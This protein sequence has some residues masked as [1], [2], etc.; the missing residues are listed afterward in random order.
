MIHKSPFPDADLP[1]VPLT[2]YVFDNAQ[3]RANKAAFIDGPTG[4]VVT[5]GALLDSVQRLAGGLT[6][7]G[8]GS[9]QVLAI[10]APN[11]P[12]YAV[13][14][15][16]VAMTGGAITTINPTYTSHEVHHQLTDAGA[17]VLV[18]VPMFLE[19]AREGA[20]GTKVEEIFV[21]GEADGDA[22]AFSELMGEPLT[23]H[24][25]VDLDDVVVLPYSSGTT[26]LSKGVI[27][28]HRNLVANVIQ[29][30]G[31]A[32]LGEHDTIVAVLPFFHIYGMQ[33]LM[34]SCLLYTSDAADE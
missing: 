29:V 23:E 19:T 32:E 31:P 20:K 3:A 21:F 33:I 18:T 5:Y 30:V 12:E 14:F 11:I 10:M 34:N 25:A 28:T 2:T 1:E 22:R 16:G 7:K 4:R 6:A 17:T 15:H 24:A 8:F 13:V 26:G 27:L 9:G